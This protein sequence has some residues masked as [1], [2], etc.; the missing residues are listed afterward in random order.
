MTSVRFEPLPHIPHTPP[1]PTQNKSCSSHT[2]TSHHPDYAAIILPTLAIALP[3][4][5]PD[6]YRNVC[7]TKAKSFEEPALPTNHQPLLGG[8]VMSSTQHSIPTFNTQS[9]FH[10]NKQ[11]QKQ[12]QQT[13]G[14]VPRAEFYA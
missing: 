1:R 4:S 6:G 12:K 13:K 5:C 14:V 3:I 11:N 8:M 9:R 7:Q 10:A 2:H